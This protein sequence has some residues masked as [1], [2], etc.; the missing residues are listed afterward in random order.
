M[1][2][3]LLNANWPNLHTL[4][5]TEGVGCSVDSLVRFLET[6]PG[7]E[8]LSLGRMMPG[9]S[10]ER[11]AQALDT[12]TPILPRLK[13]LE[14]SSAQA[15]A[16]LKPSMITLTDLLGVDM[17]DEIVIDD[18]FGWDDEWELEHAE[19]EVDEEEDTTVLIPSPWKA[20]FLRRLAACPSIRHLGVTHYENLSQLEALATIAPQLTWLDIDTCG[21]LVDSVA[22]IV[23]AHPKCISLF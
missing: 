13:T 15:A 19:D 16:L 9:R 8:D 5:L 18:Y 23:S 4:H 3:L 2:S 14:C 11:F 20:L 22:E 10:W 17:R 12:I 6:H 7:I 21:L 1:T